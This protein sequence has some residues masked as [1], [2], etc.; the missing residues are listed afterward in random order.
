MELGYQDFQVCAEQRAKV[1]QG[2]VGDHSLENCGARIFGALLPAQGADILRHDQHPGELA[3]FIVLGGQ[4]AQE[5]DGAA[6]VG[7][8][9]FQ[10]EGIRDAGGQGVLQFC[11]IALVD[12]IERGRMGRA[13]FN[14]VSVWEA[15][16]SFALGVG[17]NVLAQAVVPQNDIGRVLRQGA[18]LLFVVQQRLA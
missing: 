15:S 8:F 3:C 1:R 11:A 17:V 5:V 7:I 16:S 13:V 2:T 4:A 12:L 10:Q 6:R 14:D 18:V 9:A